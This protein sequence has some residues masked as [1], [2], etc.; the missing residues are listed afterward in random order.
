MHRNAFGCRALQPGQVVAQKHD[1][2]GVEDF[3]VGVHLVA[4]TAAVFGDVD[5]FYVPDLLQVPRRPVE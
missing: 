3:A 1:A 5:F 4:R 2:V